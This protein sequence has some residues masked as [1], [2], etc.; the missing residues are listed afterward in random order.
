MSR[1][2]YSSK[3]TATE[4]ARTETQEDVKRA[5][6]GIIARV[7]NLGEREALPHM[8]RIMD[9]A[10]EKGFNMKIYREIYWELQEDRK[11]SK[12]IIK[13]SRPKSDI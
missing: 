3:D 1:K 4:N 5:L 11:C 10:E 2:N 12:K 8:V 6:D 7:A 9:Y 13:D